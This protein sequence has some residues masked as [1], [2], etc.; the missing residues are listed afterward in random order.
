MGVA[1]TNTAVT[2]LSGAIAGAA[3]VFGK[4]IFLIKV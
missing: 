1:N 3:S 4:P 2:F